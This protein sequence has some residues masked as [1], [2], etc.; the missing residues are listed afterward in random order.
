MS[1]YILSIDLGSTV[2]KYIVMKIDNDNIILYKK[3][4][5]KRIEVKDII[6]LL[7]DELKNE[8]V[9]IEHDV[10]IVLTGCFSNEISDEYNGIKIVKVPEYTAVAYGTLLL[11][12]LDKAIIVSI[13]TGTCFIYSD[14]VEVRHI[15]GTGMGGGAIYGIGTKMYKIEDIDKMIENAMQ[16]DRK[17]VDLYIGDITKD[18]KIIDLGKDLTA[19]NLTK[20]TK[21]SNDNDFVLSLYN[22][23]CQNIGIEA[24]FVRDI[25]IKEKK[26]DKE[27]LPMIFVGGILKH[28]LIKEL[29][30]G[31]AS[32]LK[33]KFMYV[34]NNQYVTAIGAYEYYL[35][36]E[37]KNF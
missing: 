2:Q 12:K 31:I 11:A 24:I 17:N 25:I 4:H 26:W 22:V 3:N 15:G 1:K 18:D 37:R 27:E 20:T 21:E 10:E 6:G 19:S 7:C 13:G 35:L 14:L 9:D 5:Y 16:G 36:R 32:D 33:E 30:D 8:G 28:N 29:L 34:E 23:L